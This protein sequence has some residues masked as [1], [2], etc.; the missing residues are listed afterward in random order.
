MFSGEADMAVRI[1][2]CYDCIL[3][4]RCHWLGGSCVGACDLWWTAMMGL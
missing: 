4:D 2:D 1:V 3:R